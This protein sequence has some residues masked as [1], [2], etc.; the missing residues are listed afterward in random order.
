[1]FSLQV[2]PRAA[3]SLLCRRGVL[4]AFERFQS[5]SNSGVDSLR[6]SARVVAVRCIRLTCS[7][8]FKRDNARSTPRLDDIQSHRGTSHSPPCR[9]AVKR[10]IR[11]LDFD[12]GIYRRH[13]GLLDDAI[14]TAVGDEPI[15]NGDTEQ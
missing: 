6:K 10:K 14:E 12:L 3:K 2:L 9:P 11:H 5:A 7:R 13:A 8:S 1:M 4:N 15:A